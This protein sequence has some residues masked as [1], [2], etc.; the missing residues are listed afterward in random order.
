M[1]SVL[2]VIVLLGM[3]A[4]V[5]VPLV[6]QRNVKADEIRSVARFSS[7]L[8][9]LSRGHSFSERSSFG[10]GQ[11]VMPPREGLAAVRQRRL[12]AATRPA[13][14]TTGSGPAGSRSAATGSAASG[15]AGSGL[16]ASGAAAARRR[17]LMTGLAAAVTLTLLLVVVVGHVFIVFQ[18]L[19]DCAFAAG[20]MAC[21]TSVAQ[22]QAVAA[23]SRRRRDT[24]ELRSSLEALAGD[25]HVPV[26]T[27]P[28]HAPVTMQTM[29]V[30][31][32]APAQPR[33][34]AP[35]VSSEL[36]RPA[37]VPAAWAQ[38]PAAARAAAGPARGVAA[39]AARAVASRPRAEPVILAEID[40]DW[41]PA[42]P[43]PTSCVR[44]V[45]LSGKARRTRLFDESRADGIDVGDDTEL[46]ALVKRR[47]AA[48]GW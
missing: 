27:V 23:R 17:R 40:L 30:P 29:T 8:R 48:S 12:A 34:A 11:W 38:A 36:R 32:D 20:I 16:P 13:A 28:L 43:E 39:P 37:E 7:A 35:S 33:R 14:R 22:E 24:R 44:L 15:S 21:R 46:D 19:A 45:D 9:V 41:E 3:W 5:L 42:I 4:F 25:V 47:L 2:V 6:R 1:S 26:M 31:L 10:I 18:V